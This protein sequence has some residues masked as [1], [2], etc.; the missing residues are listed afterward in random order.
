MSQFSLA[1]VQQQTQE[2]VWCYDNEDIEGWLAE[3]GIGYFD[4]SGVFHYGPSPNDFV[5]DIPCPGDTE[6]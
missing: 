3:E 1:E 6:D 4:E 5:D 2:P